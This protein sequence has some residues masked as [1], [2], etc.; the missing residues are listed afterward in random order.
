MRLWVIFTRF[1]GKV[2]LVKPL[3]TDVVKLARNMLKKI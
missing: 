1:P 3:G 2:M